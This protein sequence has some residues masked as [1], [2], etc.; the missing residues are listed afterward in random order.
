M[1]VKILIFVEWIV[2]GDYYV[3]YQCWKVVVKC[4]QKGGVFEKEKLVLVYDIVLSM[5]FKKV[6]FKEKQLE[7]LELVKIYLEC[8]ELILFFKCLSYVKEFQFF[9]QLC[10]RLGKIRDVVYFYK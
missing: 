6:S 3:K 10:E 4:Y 9:V 7:Y 1:F 8:K 5:K 2:Q